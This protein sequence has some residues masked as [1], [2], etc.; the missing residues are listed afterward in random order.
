MDIKKVDNR[1]RIDLKK[2]NKYT[3]REEIKVVHYTED[4]HIEMTNSHV[5]FR[6][7][8]I[9]DES[10]QFKYGKTPK[11]YP[12]MNRLFGKY[13][14]NEV[15]ENIPVKEFEDI[16]SPFKV[17]KPDVIHL[18]FSNVGIFT[19]VQGNTSGL[20]TNLD[21]SKSYQ[22]TVKYDYL[23]IVIQFMRLLGVKTFD[24]YYS[25]TLKPLSFVNENLEILLAPI[26]NTSDKV[27]DRVKK[28]EKG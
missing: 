4:G 10:E 23:L 14:D 28:L 6:L 12:D 16:F 19:D 24:L 27:F 8:N 21:M 7:K 26:R 3:D 15:I 11:T 22:V 20:R 9:H 1:F 13:K 17:E 25:D 18:N 5:G 2:L